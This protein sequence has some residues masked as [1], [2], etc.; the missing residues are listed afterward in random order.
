M[1][2]RQGWDKVSFYVVFELEDG[3]SLLEPVVCT[4]CTWLSHRHLTYAYIVCALLRSQLGRLPAN[5]RAM[6][7]VSGGGSIMTPS[8]APAL[9][10]N[11]A[12]IN[13]CH[14]VSVYDGVENSVYA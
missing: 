11:T 10:P 1:Q 3:F 8:L 14:V 5:E 2:L 9:Y 4:M 13:T 6:K 12:R 7:G